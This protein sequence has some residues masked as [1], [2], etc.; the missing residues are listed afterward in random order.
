MRRGEVNLACAEQMMAPHVLILLL[1]FVSGI[2]G[3][4]IQ[5][6]LTLY[7]VHPK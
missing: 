4:N 6:L 3:M 7:Q 5:L 2:F 1:V